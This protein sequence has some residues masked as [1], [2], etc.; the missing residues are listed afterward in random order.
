MMGTEAWAVVGDDDDDDD[1]ARFDFRQEVPSWDY[2]DLGCAVVVVVVGGDDPEKLGTR[3][4][5]EA[6]CLGAWGY[7]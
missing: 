6:A 3:L 7:S 5:S 4:E 1:D 2:H